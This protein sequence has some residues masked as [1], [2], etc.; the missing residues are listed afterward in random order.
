MSAKCRPRIKFFKCFLFRVDLYICGFSPKI[1]RDLGEYLNRLLCVKEDDMKYFFA[2]LFGMACAISAMAQ[3]HEVTHSGAVPVYANQAWESV[4]KENPTRPP[5]ASQ[6][7]IARVLS[8]ASQMQYVREAMNVKEAGLVYVANLADFD[9]LMTYTVENPSDAYITATAE[10][11]ARHVGDY[12]FSRADVPALI[13][14]TERVQ[15]VQQAMACKRAG[16]K[17]VNS[18]RSFLE[19]LPFGFSSPSDEYR[20]QVSTFVANNIRRFLGPKSSIAIIVEIEKYT[21]LVTE[22][23]AVKNAGLVAV[24]SKTGLLELSQFAFENPTAAYQT[25]VSEFIKVNLSRYP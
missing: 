2:V 1:C 24:K 20:S 15:T 16:L 23:M 7:Q 8:V 17:V 3:S 6:L 14:L 19:I 10:F 18:A 13:K 4:L 22:A 25:A 11:I 21:V 12:I 9:Y 5:T